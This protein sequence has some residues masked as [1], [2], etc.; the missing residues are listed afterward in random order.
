MSFV[1]IPSYIHLHTVSA[2]KIKLKFCIVYIAQ[3]HRKFN[4]TCKCA[5][6]TFVEVLTI[7]VYLRVKD[8]TISYSALNL[9]TSV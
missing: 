1:C 7:G 5:L 8:A 6:M 3:R 4:Y 9:A 2:Y